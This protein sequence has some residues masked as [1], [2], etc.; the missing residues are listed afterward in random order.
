[1]DFFSGL[2]VRLLHSINLEGF[3]CYFNNPSRTICVAVS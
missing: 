2:C 1:M 3:I